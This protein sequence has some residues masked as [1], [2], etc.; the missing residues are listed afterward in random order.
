MSPRRSWTESFVRWS[1]AGTFLAT[2]HPQGVKLWSG[3]QFKG[4]TRLI[5]MSDSMYPCVYDVLWS[6]NERCAL[7]VFHAIILIPPQKNPLFNPP[8]SPPRYPVRYVCTWSGVRNNRDTASRAFVVWDVRTGREVRAFKQAEQDDEIRRL[9]EQGRY[10][11]WSSDSKYLARIVTKVNPERDN[12]AL[13]TGKMAALDFIEIYAE[14][15]VDGAEASFYQ[16]E[17]R[18]APGA[19]GLAWSPKRPAHTLEDGSG[20]ARASTHAPILSWWTPEVDKH[21]YTFEELAFLTFLRDREEAAKPKEDKATGA[22]KGK[23]AK[24]PETPKNNSS[25]STKIDTKQKMVDYVTALSKGVAPFA[26]PPEKEKPKDDED[27]ATAVRRDPL[28]IEPIH[29]YARMLRWSAA[30]FKAEYERMVLWAKGEPARLEAS[31]PAAPMTASFLR[32]MPPTDGGKATTELVKQV[33]QLLVQNESMLWSPQGDY[34]SVVAESITAQQKVRIKH[35]TGGRNIDAPIDLKK[36][37]SEGFIIKIVSFKGAGKSDPPLDE[38]K[39]KEHVHAFAWEPHAARFAVLLSP[40]PAPAGAVAAASAAAG[41]GASTGL[42]GTSAY[43]RSIAFYTFSEKSRWTRTHEIDHSALGGALYQNLF[44]SPLGEHLVMAD[45]K[46]NTLKFLDCKEYKTL[47]TRENMTGARALEWD[48]SGRMVATIKAVPY[49]VPD[50]NGG[51]M[52][53]S[54]ISGSDEQSNGCVCRFEGARCSSSLPFSP[55]APPVPSTFIP[56]Q[57]HTVVL[58]G[59]AHHVRR[60]VQ[61]LPILVAPAPRRAAVRIRALAR[62]QH[63]ARFCEPLPGRGQSSRVSQ[64]A[65]Q[66]PRQAAR[67]RGLSRTPRGPRGGCARQLCFEGRVRGRRSA[68]RC[69]RGGRRVGR[70]RLRGRSR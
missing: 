65:P 25:D 10:W 4:E 2:V 62:A 38:L 8:P 31:L 66:A 1:P 15:I 35:K 46:F 54:H 41:A 16:V 39:I 68:A 70:G 60:K 14:V 22:D 17:S 29:P 27:T 49:P 69:A 23:N 7:F 34:C 67:N 6:P 43:S 9:Q 13:K 51:W 44:W 33:R 24:K 55:R 47:D 59:C 26:P 56:T 3:K 48:P 30:D 36:M 12:P 45:E 28:A 11:A 40:P 19:R 53:A 52:K 37:A 50:H 58:S 21:D 5:H 20:K 63:A 18:A 64:R 57:L 61:G 42:L 32:V